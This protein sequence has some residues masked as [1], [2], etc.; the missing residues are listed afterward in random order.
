[1]QKTVSLPGDVS[2]LAYTVESFLV[3]TGIGRTKLHEEMQS[4]RLKARRVGRRLL[5]AKAD[6]DAWLAS[7]PK[8]DTLPER[9]RA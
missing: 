3:A 8:R 9:K 7:L 6:A 5:I 4:G 2:P 1:M